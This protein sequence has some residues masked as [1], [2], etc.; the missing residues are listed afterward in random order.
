MKVP[1]ISPDPMRAEAVFRRLDS[2]DAAA[3]SDFCAT[4][5]SRDEQAFFHPHPFSPKEITRICSQPGQDYFCGAF[6]GSAMVAYGMLRGWNEGFQH[7]SLGLAV[8]PD[9]RGR[10]WGRLMLGHLHGF[11]RARQ[12]SRIRLTVY[13][14]NEEALR[15]FLLAGYRLASAVGPRAVAWLELGTIAILPKN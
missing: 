1:E 4:L 5:A 7:P 14:H 8:R 10:G 6:L 13:R 2:R 9:Q 11:A 12:V 15:L 3:L